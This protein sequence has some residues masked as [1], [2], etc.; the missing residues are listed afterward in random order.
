[1][2]VNFVSEQANW[3]PIEDEE[4]NAVMADDN[5]VDQDNNDAAAFNMEDVVRTD[6]V[7][8]QQVATAFMTDVFTVNNIADIDAR[9]RESDPD[10][11]D[12]N[13][14]PN[15]DESGNERRWQNWVVP[16]FQPSSTSTP[17]ESGQ[18]E[19]FKQG[20]FTARTTSYQTTQ[21]TNTFT[22]SSRKY[23]DLLYKLGGGLYSDPEF[24]ASF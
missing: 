4:A 19:E 2:Q 13:D 20:I 18:M 21:E 12:E 22:G 3:K 16:T 11:R 10:P 8:D 15:F 23:Q 5:D 1:M 24:P 6:V 14:D 7:V 9:K 17:T